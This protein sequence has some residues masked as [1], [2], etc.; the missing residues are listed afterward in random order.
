MLANADHATTS[1]AQLSARLEQTVTQRL[2]PA[3][4]RLPALADDTQQALRALQAATASANSSFVAI[5]Q[6]AARLNEKDGVVDR[7]ADGTGA[8]SHAADS[9]GNATL[10]RI[11]RVAEDVSRAARQL[12]RTANGIHD[13]PQSLIF[14]G[15]AVRPG[16]GETGF[17]APTLN[18]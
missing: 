8:L 17:V 15:G 16:P 2:D 1:L 18:P 4:A 6:T 11:N 14:G 5:G 10:P 3:L 12:G 13:Q 9:F 7:L